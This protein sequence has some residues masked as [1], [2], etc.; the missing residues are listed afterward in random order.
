[1]ALAGSATERE[2]DATGVLKPHAEAAGRRLA[3]YQVGGLR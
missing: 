3:D 1:M 2:R